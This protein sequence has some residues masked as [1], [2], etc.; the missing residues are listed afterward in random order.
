MQSLYLLYW[1]LFNVSS[2]AFIE[3]VF[4]L[5][6]VLAYGNILEFGNVPLEH[7]DGSPP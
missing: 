1:P 6:I 5:A 2:A 4:N 7:R 3:L